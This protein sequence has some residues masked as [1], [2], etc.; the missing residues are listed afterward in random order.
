MKVQGVAPVFQV[1][2][3]GDSLKYYKEVLGFT[4]EF[5]FGD[6][7]GVRAVEKFRAGLT[8]RLRDID[9]RSD[10]VSFRVRWPSR[11]LSVISTRLAS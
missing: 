11:L 9:Y 1:S 7:A 10:W 6:Y 8:K 3:L 2:S 5:R 4:E